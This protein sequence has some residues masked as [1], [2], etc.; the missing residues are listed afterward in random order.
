MAGLRRRGWLG[1]ALIASVAAILIMASAPSEVSATPR[2]VTGGY[3]DWGIKADFRNYIENVSPD[4]VTMLSGGA[5]LNGDGTYR[6]PAA[7]SGS[8]DADT[9]DTTASFNG[10]VQYQAHNVN[11]FGYVLDL[12]ISDIRME[13]DGTTG[14]IIADVVSR[15]QNTLQ[16]VSYPDV[17]L[18]NLDLTSTPPVETQPSVSWTNIPSELTADAVTA[19]GGFYLAGEPFD[20]ASPV[21]NLQPVG[22]LTWKVSTHAFTTSMS[23]TQAHATEAPAVKD[24]LNGFVFPTHSV[25]YNTSTHVTAIDFDGA[26][27]L[28]NTGFGDFKIKLDNPQITID[29][30]GEGQLE[31]DVSYCL[32]CTSNPFNSPALDTTITTF[33]YNPAAVTVSGGQYTW[34]ITPDWASVG[35]QFAQEY[36]DALDVS[37]RGFFRATGAGT[38]VNKPPAPI[39]ITFDTWVCGTDADCDGFDDV[40]LAT[41]TGPSNTNGA[42][43]NCLAAYNYAQVNTDGNFID[44]PAPLTQDDTSV[45]MSDASGDTCDADDDDDGLADSVET[46]LPGASCAS[47]T[48][49]LN[50]LNPDS[51]GDAYLDTAECAIGTDP[52]SVATK[53]TQAQCA[54]LAG[55][56]QSTDTDGDRLQDRTEVCGYGSAVGNVDSDGDGR[57]DGCEA[58]SLNTLPAVNSLDQLVLA[59]AIVGDLL[60]PFVWNADL[61]KDGANN[62]ADQLLLAGIL[63]LGGGAGPCAS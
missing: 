46:S 49:A 24:A 4:G 28:G 3:L 15:D 55:V 31:A 5:T 32:V 45:V 33:D 29:S 39:T 20:G 44:N 59:Q 35:N 62:S 18:V 6:F 63:T 10:T 2:G 40:P 41:H 19:F 9:D 52:A 57:R 43:D 61:N 27:I 23:L 30:L 8:H 47:A 56:S 17:D 50:P 7:A 22:Y 48:G 42:V 51:D 53:P 34:T 21:L 60:G 12:T 54:A 13:I 26:L 16:Y 38:D 37:L 58:G 11:P 1:G 14:V 25:S 36:L